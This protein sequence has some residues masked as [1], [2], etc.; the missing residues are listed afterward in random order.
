[1]SVAV[2]GAATL[3]YHWYLNGSSLA[4]A[5]SNTI[6]FASVSVTNTGSYQVVIT[7]NSGAVTSSVALVSITNQ[8]VSFL[9]GGSALKLSGGKFI[10]QLTNLTGQGQVVV[11]ASTNL[12]Q[13]VPLFTNPSGFGTLMF[14]DTA[15]GTFPHRYY[16]A[17]TP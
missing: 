1:L 17:T 12:L 8:P 11:S 9:T 14:T 10:L 13:W 6:N 7:N 16:R 3:S 2:T 5:Q 15:A 4:G